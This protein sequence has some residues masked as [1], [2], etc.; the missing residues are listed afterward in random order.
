MRGV[1][2]VCERPQWACHE[3]RRFWYKVPHGS[4]VLK[5]RRVEIDG[6]VARAVA[7]SQAAAEPLDFVA[8]RYCGAVAR[9]FR[10][11]VPK[12]GVEG[13]GAA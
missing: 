11:S 9:L 4:R 5:I 12:C 3:P 10:A 2:G 7:G 1:G 6:G 8:G 13:A